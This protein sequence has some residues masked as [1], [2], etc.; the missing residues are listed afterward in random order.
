MDSQFF[1]RFAMLSEGFNQLKV[2]LLARQCSKFS[3]SRVPQKKPLRNTTLSKQR[4]TPSAPKSEETETETGT[5]TTNSKILSFFFSGGNCWRCKKYGENHKIQNPWSPEL[6]Q[7][8]ELLA[9]LKAGQWT[10]ALAIL[11]ALLHFPPR[12]RGP[13]RP[14]VTWRPK[15]RKKESKGWFYRCAFLNQLVES[16]STKRRWAT[17]LTWGASHSKPNLCPKLCSGKLFCFQQSM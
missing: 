15:K 16:R 5:E 11:D 6:F 13:S 9:R 17:S 7:T 8:L 4:H 12:G 3:L 14:N 2:R 1:I 10:L